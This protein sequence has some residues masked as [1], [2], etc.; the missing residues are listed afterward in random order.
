MELKAWHSKRNSS[1]KEVDWQFSPK[2]IRGKIKHLYP[3][4][5]F[6]CSGVLVSN[7]ERNFTMLLSNYR[8]VPLIILKGSPPSLNYKDDSCHND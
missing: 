2:D 7:G 5:I 3:I 1:Q 6:K 8:K 4:L